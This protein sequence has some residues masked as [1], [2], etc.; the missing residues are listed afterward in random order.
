MLTGNDVT[1]ISLLGGAPGNFWLRILKV[2]L[3]F[4]IHAQLTILRLSVNSR[5]LFITPDEGES[6]YLY[7]DDGNELHHI[8]L[9]RYMMAFHAVETTRNT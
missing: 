8:E 2:R 6:L 9:P 4:C 5:R 3:Q 7:G 1:A